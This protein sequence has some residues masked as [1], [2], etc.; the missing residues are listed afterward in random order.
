MCIVAGKNMK[1]KWSNNKEGKENG[2]ILVVQD[3]DN[4]VL[5]SKDGTPL[6]H[7]DTFQAC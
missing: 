7:T 5:Y 6:W 4:I 2:A 3:D 1:E